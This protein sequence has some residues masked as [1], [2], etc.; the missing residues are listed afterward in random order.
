MC[1]TLSE[2]WFRKLLPYRQHGNSGVIL[3]CAI[4]S[5]MIY[6]QAPH[7]C[8]EWCISPNM[9]FHTYGFGVISAFRVT[10]EHKAEI[11]SFEFNT[12]TISEAHL[13]SLSN[14]TS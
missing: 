10:A 12:K 4:I 3:T 2:R 9:S 14:F 6:Y 7:E 5:Y 11:P 8:T 13:C 1:K